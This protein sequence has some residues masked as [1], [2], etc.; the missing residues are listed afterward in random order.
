MIK[1]FGLSGAHA[2]GKTTVATEVAETLGLEFIPS[3]TS[4]VFEDYGLNPQEVLDPFTRLSI[5]Q[6]ILDRAIDSWENAGRLWITDRT[7]LD[8]MVYLMNDSFTW[9]DMWYDNYLSYV[10]RCERA[11]DKY[12]NVAILVQPDGVIWDRDSS[13]KGRDSRVLQET[14]NTLY[15]GLMLRPV[16]DVEFVVLDESLSSSEKKIAVH[17]TLLLEIHK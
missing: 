14:M 10:D 7:P 15:K 5:Q 1:G 8:F 13:L 11:L 6:V 4:Q 12:F 17:D 2:T 3:R 9:K 16:G